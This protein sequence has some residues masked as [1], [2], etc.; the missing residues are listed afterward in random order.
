MLGLPLTPTGETIDGLPVYTL[1]THQKAA[2]RERRNAAVRAMGA[3]G[4]RGEPVTPEMEREFEE[5][6]IAFLRS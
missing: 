6:R 1:G 5:A 2:A 4:S 3:A